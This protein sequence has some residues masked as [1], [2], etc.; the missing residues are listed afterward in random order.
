MFAHVIGEHWLCRRI[1][2]FYYCAWLS[3]LTQGLN[4]RGG[5]GL[6]LHTIWPT[7]QVP[8][9]VRSNPQSQANDTVSVKKNKA[10]EVLA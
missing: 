6:N 8:Q 5:W 2:S 1:V 7:L 3:T 4:S 9:G 10:K